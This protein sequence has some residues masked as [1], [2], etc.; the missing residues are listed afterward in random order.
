MLSNAFLQH[1]CGDFVDAV[2]AKRV[3]EL[4]LRRRAQD[5]LCSLI[6]M[7]DLKGCGMLAPQ[8]WGLMILFSTHSLQLLRLGLTCVTENESWSGATMAALLVYQEKV[9]SHGTSG[10]ATGRCISPPSFH[11]LY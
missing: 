4:L 11:F 5:A 8:R 7:E 9:Q 10:S 6:G 3:I 2:S 1:D